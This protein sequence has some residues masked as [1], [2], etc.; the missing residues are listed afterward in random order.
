MEETLAFLQSEYGGARGF[1]SAV[2]LT[3][4]EIAAVEQLLR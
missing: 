4:A 1:F 3:A 2:G